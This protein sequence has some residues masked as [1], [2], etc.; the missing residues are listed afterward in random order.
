METG[1][2]WLMN[3]L[4][5][6]RAR[7]VRVFACAVAALLIGPFVA[8]AES[9]PA[10]QFPA[11]FSKFLPV[12]SAALPAA[13]DKRL[14]DWLAAHRGEPVIVNFW[15]TWCPPCREE[16][17]ALQ[18]VA[19]RW[20]SESAKRKLAVVTLAVADAP[21]AVED[22]LWEVDVRLPALAD[23][24][25]FISRAWG[26]YALPAT[27]LLDNRHRIRYRALGPIDWDSAATDRILQSLFNSPRQG[28]SH[29][30]P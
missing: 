14:D 9:T 18:G 30:S 1:R 28:A 5:D 23:R 7:H 21:Q 3:F 19:K 26:A 8:A 13:A 24:D 27:F 11:Q 16:M 4:L 22:F 15:A 6:A 10:P 20:G 17:P 2:G 29:G 25:R 12:S